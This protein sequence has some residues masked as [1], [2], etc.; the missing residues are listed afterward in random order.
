MSKRSV[1]MALAA[2]ML[3]C[4]FGAMNAAAG[5]V[6]VTQDSGTFNFTLTADGHG[7]FTIAYSNAQ[8]TTINDVAIPTGDIA[9]QLPLLAS[10]FVTSTVTS[11]ALTSYT[12]SQPGPNDKFFGVGPGAIDTAHLTYV[13]TNGVAINPSF[14]N[15]SGRITGAPAPLLETTATAPTVYDFSPFQNGGEITRTYTNVGVNFAA[16]IA[17]GGTIVGSGAF[18]DQ[19]APEPASIALLSIG[20][21]GM[22]AFRRFFKR[23]ARA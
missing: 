6:I 3:A 11:G 21:S 14:L 13:L 20:I 9:S 22:I 8:L 23:P 5:T 12:I 10:H 17:N 7:N 16:V 1:L 2:G 19:A 4:S 15:L 18:A